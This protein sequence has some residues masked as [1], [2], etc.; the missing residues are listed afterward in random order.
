MKIAYERHPL[1]E[2]R[3]QELRDAG[4][5]ILDIRFKPVEV[6]QPGPEQ[7]KR[8]YVRKADK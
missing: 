7:S 4:F 3:K 8:Q 2:G 1:A 6:D 5:K